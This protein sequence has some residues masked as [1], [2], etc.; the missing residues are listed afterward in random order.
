MLVLL[1]NVSPAEVVVAPLPLPIIIWF[2]VL[3]MVACFVPNAVSSPVICDV[4]KLGICAVVKVPVVILAASSEGIWVVANTC[5]L[6][7]LI[8]MLLVART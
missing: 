1:L 8:K 6:Y 3:L 5:V 2:A 7:L 4:G